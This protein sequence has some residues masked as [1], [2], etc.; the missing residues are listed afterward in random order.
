[1][2]SG[3]AWS[4][5]V[6]G[7]PPAEGEPFGLRLP[8]GVDIELDEAWITLRGLSLTPCVAATAQ[9]GP[10]VLP[11][12]MAD[13]NPSR[14]PSEREISVVFPLVPGTS[15]WQL[16]LAFPTACYE[17]LWVLLGRAAVGTE[18]PG[19]EAA[20]ELSLRVRGRWTDG[21]Q[22]GEIAW[23]GAV[24]DARIWRWDDVSGG[25]ASPTRLLR[26]TLDAAAPW[27]GIDPRTAR[28]EAATWAILEGVLDGL[29]WEVEA[30]PGGIP[31]VSPGE[32]EGD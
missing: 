6:T 1:V 17:G 18:L 16:P 8:S 5:E 2:L 7:S 11:I 29:R 27:S 3:A 15:L 19:G 9:G 10:A 24:S 21:A 4:I 14:D 13:H 23:D 31:R 32:E 28:P 30:L 26:G 20:P 25:E 12:A 22:E